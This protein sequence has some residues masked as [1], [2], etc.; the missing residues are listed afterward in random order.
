MQLTVMVSFFVVVLMITRGLWVS[1]IVGRILR[2]SPLNFSSSKCEKLLCNFSF[3]IWHQC[4]ALKD[5]VTFFNRNI[6][7]RS[8][9]MGTELEAGNNVFGKDTRIRQIWET[10]ALECDENLTNLIAAGQ[11]SKIPWNA[12][13]RWSSRW[14]IMASSDFTWIVLF[15]FRTT[16]TK[17]QRVRVK[18]PLQSKAASW[19]I[20]IRA[21]QSNFFFLVS[22]TFT[23]GGLFQPLWQI[24]FKLIFLPIKMFHRF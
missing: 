12:Q 1:T 3:D 19:K 2:R 9:T 24:L 23:I 11:T 10:V 17:L 6:S 5:I 16:R 4:A 22:F 7:N 20:I 13:R 15:H 14:Y 8:K 21:D 18:G